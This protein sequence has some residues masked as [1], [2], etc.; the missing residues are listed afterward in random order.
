M[1]ALYLL[2]HACT[3]RTYVWDR[4]LS[5]DLLSASP[6]LLCIL[7]YKGMLTALPHLSA[8]FRCP[9]QFLDLSSH[10]E[11]NALVALEEIDRARLNQT[12]LDSENCYNTINL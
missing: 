9:Q 1:R 12:S 7:H 5:Q 11:S 6:F 10:I 2:A 4:Y 8:L 3:R